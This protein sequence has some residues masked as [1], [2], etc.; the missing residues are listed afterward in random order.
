MLPLLCAQITKHNSIEGCKLSS[1]NIV[2]TPFPNL[3]K[4]EQ[5]MVTGQVSFHQEKDRIV[6]PCEKDKECVKLMEKTKEWRDVDLRGERER[7]DKEVAA[8]RKKAYKEKEKADKE[9]RK[10]RAEEAAAKDY[11]L[12]DIEEKKMSNLDL[13]ATEDASAAVDFEED[14]M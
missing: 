5:T 10:Q 11:G 9:L 13:E 3:H 2:I 8:A 1:T 7:R 4:D 6:V 12:L 14:F